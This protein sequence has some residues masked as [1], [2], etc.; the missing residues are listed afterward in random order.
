MSSGTIIDRRRFPSPNPMVILEEVTYWSDDFRVKGMLARPK[1]QGVY[2]GLLYLR[3]GIQ[4][5]GTV[6]PAR[7]AQFAIQGMIVFAPYYRGNRGSEGRDEFVHS[8]VQDAISGVDVLKQIV[9]VDQKS[10]HIIGYSRGGAM[11]LWTAAARDDIRST[12][13]WAGMSDIIATYAERI[14]MR[15]MMK[16]V[17]G[18]STNTGVE[19]YR[20]RNPLQQLYRIQHPLLILHGE[21]DEHVHYKQAIHLYEQLTAEGK[22][23]TLYTFK[24][25]T[26]FIPGKENRQL[27]RKV[28]R[29]M[30][31]QAR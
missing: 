9:S 24:N 5:I 10:L 21:Q 7:I 22:E 29:W 4:S 11:A 27:V 15:R 19:N 18:K 1:T 13:I 20:H 12:V 25:F 6:R 23:V 17:I 2:P 31:Q 14:D 8:E 30:K 28:V 3:G 16:R 26:H